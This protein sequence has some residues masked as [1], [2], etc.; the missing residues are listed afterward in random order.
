MIN[1]QFDKAA[2]FSEGLAP[3]RQSG[4]WGFVGP[5]GKMV[6]NP[7]FDEAAAFAGGLARVKAGGQTGYIDA[8]G[9]YVWNPTK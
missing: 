7:Q 2:A 3:V 8:N 5:N 9:K 1:P 4:H 6:I